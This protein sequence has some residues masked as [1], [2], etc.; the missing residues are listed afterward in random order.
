[1]EHRMVRLAAIVCVV[2]LA[3]CLAG[4]MPGT[5][6]PAGPATTIRL[7]V[8]TFN[9]FYG[10]DELNLST[11][12]WCL[13]PDGCPETLEKVIEAIRVMGADIV[14]LEEGEHNTRAIAE[15]L[16]WHWSERMQTVSRFPLIDPPGGDGLYVFAAPSPGRVV[17]LAN[18]HLPSDPYGPYLVRDGAPPGEIMALE[19]SVRLPAIQDQLRV[20]PG[21]AAA[22]IPVF[23]TGDFNSPSHLDW[24]AAV[25]AVRE[26]ISYPFDWPVSRALADA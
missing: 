13:R 8:M 19:T 22:G 4:G 20:L 23:L 25:A 16:G 10:G 3:L 14:G 11:G 17:A 15:A 9:I 18:V 1:M 6:A 21:L 24:T 7:R 2:L 26:K 12:N 5:A